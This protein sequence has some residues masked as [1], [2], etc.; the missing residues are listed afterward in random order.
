MPLIAKMVREYL[1]NQKITIS[2]INEI[3]KYLENKARKDKPIF[4]W[5]HLT[6]THQP[7]RPDYYSFK[8]VTNKSRLEYFSALLKDEICWRRYRHRSRSIRKSQTCITS[9]QNNIKLVEELYEAQIKRMD[10]ELGKFISHLKELSILR[11]RNF[12]IIVTSDHGEEF[13]EM[14]GVAHSL[15]SHSDVVAKIPIIIFESWNQKHELREE[16]LTTLYMRLLN[17]TYRM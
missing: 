13:M 11:N 17:G 16:F 8:E 5:Y 12:V 4:Y 10:R 9:F 15:N 7:Y 6:D 14:G 1:T 3:Q 2:D